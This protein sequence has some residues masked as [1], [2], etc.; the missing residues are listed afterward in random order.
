MDIT[1]AFRCL[2]L[3][4][5]KL[6]Q[7]RLT[8]RL[9]VSSQSILDGG[10]ILMQNGDGIDSTSFSGRVL[11]IEITLYDEE[12]MDLDGIHCSYREGIRFPAP[13]AYVTQDVK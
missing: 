1:V 3:A 7:D 4:R 13:L 5:G 10:I 8:Y 6:F 11:A 2:Q 9:G 12:A